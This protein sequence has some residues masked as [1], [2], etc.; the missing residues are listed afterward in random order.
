MN[1]IF[2]EIFNALPRQ[3]PGNL[4]STKKALN[5]LKSLPDNPKILDIGCGNG[6]QTIQLARSTRGNIIAIDNNKH[7]LNHLKEQALKEGLTNNIKCINRDMCA[8]DFSLNEFDLIWAEGSIYIIGFEKGLLELS[9]LLK[10]KSYLACSEVIWLKNN[11][12]DDLLNFWQQEYPDIKTKEENIRIID[13]AGYKLLDSFV[14]PESAWW[15]D[16][17]TP[18]EVHLKELR[19]KYNGNNEALDLIKLTQ[20]EIDLYRKYSDYYGY[21]FFIMQTND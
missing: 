19:N 1:N 3:G 12:P 18:L 16:F 6:M 14:L 10:P 4:E 2:Y 20:L 13:D 5:I 21:C 8:L 15:K 7:S 11:P 9:K 17:Y